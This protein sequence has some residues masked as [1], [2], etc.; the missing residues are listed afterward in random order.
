MI[1]EKSHSF[2][3]RKANGKDDFQIVL[4]ASYWGRITCERKLRASILRAIEE[5]R[6][7]RKQPAYADSLL[8]HYNNDG[9]LYVIREFGMLLSSE[10]IIE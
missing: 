1:P 6:T 3:V 4:R 8:K 10:R 2:I 7:T 9:I 5:Y